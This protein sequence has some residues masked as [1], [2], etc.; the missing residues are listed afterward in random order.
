MEIIANLF[1]YVLEFWYNICQNYGVSIILFA[2][3]IKIILYPLTLK[4]KK[5]KDPRVATKIA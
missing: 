4:Q 3:T 1:G 2:I 5:E